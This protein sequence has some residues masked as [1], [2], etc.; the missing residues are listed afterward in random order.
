LRED[1][2]QIQQALRIAALA[3]VAQTYIDRLE[4]PAREV[5]PEDVQQ[6][7]LALMKEARARLEADKE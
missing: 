3:G 2:R 7:R 1:A 4:E 5:T 6:A